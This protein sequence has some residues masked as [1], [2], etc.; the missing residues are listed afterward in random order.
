MAAIAVTDV[1]A[2]LVGKTEI[3]KVSKTHVMDLTFGNGTLTYPTGGIPLSTS[4]LGMKRNVDAVQICDA[5]AADGFV[6]KWDK[7]NNKILIFTQGAL[8]GAAGAVAM[9]DFPVTAGVGTDAAL[10]LS[11][12][13]SAGAGT[14]RWGGLK[15]LAAT[16]TP[17]ATTLRVIVRGW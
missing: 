16:D 13:G 17:A 4:L 6:Y 12:T 2:T 3:G 9:D 14:H 11:L 10:S 8:V 15:E 5:S 1:T 7:T